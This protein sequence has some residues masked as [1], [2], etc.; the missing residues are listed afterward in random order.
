MQSLLFQF[1]EHFAEDR[2]VLASNILQVLT[3]AERER[4]VY[5]SR[6]AAVAAVSC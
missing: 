1:L 5:F 6:C 3:L 2:Q 4:V